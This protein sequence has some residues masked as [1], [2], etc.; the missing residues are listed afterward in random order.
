M[1]Y[2]ANVWSLGLLGIHNGKPID[3]ELDFSKDAGIHCRHKNLT[4]GEEV[5]DVII[6]NALADMTDVVARDDGRYN[7]SNWCYMKKL[8]HLANKTF[9]WFDDNFFS[10]SSS[11]EYACC[12]EIRPENCMF[13]EPLKKN[14]NMVGR[15]EWTCL[16]NV[17]FLSFSFPENYWTCSQE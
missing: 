14:P 10:T 13:Y 4:I 11:L 7:T 8:P 1:P 15:P 9:T 3:I 2:A 12:G 17:T 16:H 6:G 5:S